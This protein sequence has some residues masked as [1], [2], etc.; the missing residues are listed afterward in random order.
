LGVEKVRPG[1]GHKLHGHY[2]ARFTHFQTATKLVTDAPQKHSS[3]AYRADIDG[4]RGIAVL[5]VLAYHLAILRF[6]GRFAF[7]GGFVGVDVFFVISG[8]LISSVILSEIYASKFSLFSFYERRIRRIFPALI[9]M[10]VVTSLLAYKYLLPTELI[11]Y[12]KS[13]VAA[14]FSVSNVYFWQQS[15]YF[16]APAAMKPL[17]HTWSL[18]VEE[19]F[20]IF[21]PLFLM[22][23]CRLFPKKLRLSIVVIAVLSFLVSAIGAFEFPVS[24]F[25]LAHT[26]AW[27]LLLGTILSL[28]ILP[29]ISGTIHRNIAAGIGVL[30]IL[31]AGLLFT[32][33]TPFPGV[34]ALAP[35]LGAGLIIAAGQTGTSLVGRALSFKPLVFVGLIS[36]SLY[37]WHWPIIVFH[38][39]GALSVHG[40]SDRI[41]KLIVILASFAAATLSWKFVEVPF[42]SGRLKLAGASVFKAGFGGVAVAGAIGVVMIL[43]H[44]IPS[45]FPASA[46]KI[47]S[48]LDQKWTDEYRTGSCFISS[49]Y[50]YKDFNFSLCLHEDGKRKNFLLIGDSHAAQLWYGLSTTLSGVN[51][52]QATAS[53]CRPTIE[54]SFFSEDRCL[55]LMNYVFSDFLPTHHVDALLIAGRW[56]PEDIPRL[57]HT[58]AWAKER[59]IEVIV[60]GPMLQYDSPLPRLLATSIQNNEPGKPYD[61][62]IAEY[63]R[64]DSAMSKLAANEWNVRYISF[65][66]TLCGPASCV[67]YAAIDEPLQSDYGHLTKDGSVLVARRWRDSGELP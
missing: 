9:V 54:Q 61:H 6:H 65:F 50:A 33:S 30:L 64:M 15:G 44:G 39:V 16:D 55:H 22:L 43:S 10:L 21:F 24:S 3:L 23:V 5:M 32:T 58:I 37:L 59:Q 57:S 12:A 27:E 41:A 48:Y 63:E 34:A 45:R 2:L 13:L 35:C 8:F 19:Q 53:G 14:T 36:Y 60:F 52:M 38:G 47:A 20:Y 46:V 49:E 4:L 67:E 7:S 40:V 56:T 51:V 28:K 18:G 42:R 11:D 17:L 29:Q 25:Y 31:A 66:K 1:P 62:R 26:R